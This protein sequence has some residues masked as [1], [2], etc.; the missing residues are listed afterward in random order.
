LF[1]NGRRLRLEPLEARQL[2]AGVPELAFDINALP[3]G[4]G[5]A[6]QNL[7]A[8]GALAYFLASDGVSGF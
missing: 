5:S 3:S 1:A 2:L 7:F 4:L 8:A 6:P